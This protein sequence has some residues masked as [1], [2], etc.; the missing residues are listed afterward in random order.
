MTF[1]DVEHRISVRSLSEDEM[2]VLFCRVARGEYFLATFNAWRGSDGWLYSDIKGF[3]STPE[4]A[5]DE[6]PVGPITSED[7]Q[8]FRVTSKGRFCIRIEDPWGN[9]AR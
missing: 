5:G 4:D 7:T 3:V 1:D 2:R 9:P 8:F 6:A